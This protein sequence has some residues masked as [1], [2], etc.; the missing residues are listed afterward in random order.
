VPITIDRRRNT[1][2]DDHF[3]QQHQVASRAFLV[4][5]KALQPGSPMSSSTALSRLLD[6]LDAGEL[7]LDLLA[8]GQQLAE[9]LVVE[10]AVGAQVQ[11]ADV[12]ERGSES[13]W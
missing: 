8:L 2:G 11:L 10:P 3:T 12:P 5:G 9:V 4:A 1:S 6:V 13:P 7:E